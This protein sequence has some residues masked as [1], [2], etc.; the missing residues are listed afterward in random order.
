MGPLFMVQWYGAA[1]PGPVRD[2]DHRRIGSIPHRQ[3]HR[4]EQDMS[5]IIG[6]GLPLLLAAALLILLATGLHR[7]PEGSEG[8]LARRDGGLEV[9]SPGWHLTR[10][11]SGGFFLFPSGDFEIRY[12]TE[13]E[14]EI[15]LRDGG[16]ARAAFLFT[17]EAPKGSAADL[18]RE[19]GAE[20]E[21]RLE[22]MLLDAIEIGAA[23]YS[24]LPG[25]DSIDPLS[26]AI[27]G[28]LGAALSGT[29][30]AVRGVEAAAWSTDG[31]PTPIDIPA[32]PLRRIVFIGVDGGDWKTID[33]M[34]EEGLLPNFRR[35]VE[36]GATGPLRSMEPMLSPLLWT[37]M[38]TGKLPEEHGILNFTEVDPESGEKIPVTR[39]SRKV[40]AFWNMMSEYGRTV[41]IIGWL[42]TYPAERINGVMVSDRTGYLA[43]ASTG[44]SDAPS[45]AIFPEERRGEIMELVVEGKEVSYGEMKGFMHIGE[46]EFERCR[47]N[48]FD[49]DNPVNNMI[50]IYAAAKSYRNVTLHLL[51]KGQPDFL[52]VYF[53]FIDAVGHLFMP[54]APPRMEGVSEEDYERFKD[55]IREAYIY[56]DRL[57][58]EI[59]AASGP[60]TVFMFASDH[61]FKSGDSRL[62]AGAGITGGHASE[63]HQIDGIVGLLGDGIRRG[64][65]IEDASV[66]DI[67]PT[68][69][70]LAGFPKILDMPGKA[71]EE[72]FDGALREAL[73][74]NSVSTLERTR[75]DEAQGRSLGEADEAMMKKLEALGYLTPDNPMALNNL[76][77]RY[78]KEGEHE[79]AIEQ[80][81]KA[82]EIQPNYA[83]ALNNLGISYGSLGRLDE[84]ERSFERAIEADPK[85]ISAMNNLAVICLRTQRLNEARQYAQKALEIEP[86]Y[87]S[88]HFTLG[89]IYATAGQLAQ[90]EKEFEA[91]LRIEPG[92]R[93][94]SAT[95]E[96][97][98]QQ[99]RDRR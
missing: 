36:E 29:P 76:G 43:F 33:P 46:A 56:Q 49:P 72:A 38:A 93:S 69:L 25:D 98:R 89:S 27:A 58:G 20:F 34:M 88:A 99:M 96:R 35:F 28:E 17:L 82:L 81:E 86:Q 85:D 67:A 48:T 57:I 79:K 2:S 64:C 61:G 15:M 53:E 62:K 71:I 97:L 77:L 50:L 31:A 65:A 22:R 11:F 14:R 44:P 45:G 47:S 13:G 23:E 32:E 54:Y 5:R 9:Y 24:P 73:D 63:W 26:I 70:A 4:G 51:E 66:I 84:A 60:G 94:F 41:D 42:A 21:P 19:F 39:L 40:D 92:N 52:A 18:Y 87:A 12:P 78:Q 16:A 6:T 3:V 95:L 80:F 74:R 83:A 59:M 30:I 90:A 10:P 8:V 68:I 55:A 75:P 37:T 1:P 7:V 91:A